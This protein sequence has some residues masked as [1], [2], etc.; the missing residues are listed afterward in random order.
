MMMMVMTVCWQLSTEQCVL[1]TLNPRITSSAGGQ[2][3]LDA[4]R[5]QKIELITSYF[6]P[7]RT[8]AVYVLTIPSEGPGN[9]IQ[10]SVNTGVK[11]N[12]QS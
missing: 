8:A 6:S 5:R 12:N 1:E 2:T 9:Q 11:S 10:T 4:F 3:V 7:R